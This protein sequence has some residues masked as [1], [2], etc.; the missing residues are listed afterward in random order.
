MAIHAVGKV[1]MTDLS[2]EPLMFEPQT[3]T[4]VDTPQPLAPIRETLPKRAMAVDNGATSVL[5]ALKH[6]KDCQ[7]RFA[8]FGLVVNIAREADT[9][10]T[11]TPILLTLRHVPLFS[12]RRAALKAFFVPTHTS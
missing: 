4:L 2:P 11:S 1:A 10:P 5:T 8:T 6:P 3:G 12:P 9:V 7:M